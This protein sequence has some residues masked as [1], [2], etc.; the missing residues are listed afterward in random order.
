MRNTKQ[1]R[2]YLLV[3]G[4]CLPLVRVRYFCRIARDRFGACLILKGTD[5]S[6]ARSSSLAYSTVQDMYLTNDDHRAILN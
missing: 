2:Q 4:V 6:F 3:T 1:K 5:G